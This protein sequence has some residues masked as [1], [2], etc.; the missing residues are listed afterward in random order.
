M[1]SAACVL[2][3]SVLWLVGRDEQVLDAA[4]LAALNFLHEAHLRSWVYQS[5]GGLQSPSNIATSS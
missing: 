1:V 3:D 5:A 4:H 2:Q